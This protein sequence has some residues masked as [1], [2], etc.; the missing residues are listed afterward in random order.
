MRHRG[1]IT[2]WNDARGFGFI[3][4]D[5]G[6]ARVFLHIKAF[7][8]A[9]RRPAGNERVVYAL[10]RDGKRGPSAASAAFAGAHPARRGG[11]GA[12]GIAAASAFLFLL[13]ISIAAWAGKLPMQVPVLYWGASL[14]AFAAYLVDKSAARSGR[15]RTRESSLHLC[16][17]VGG[18]AGALLAQ[19]TLRHKSRKQSFQ[20]V[21]WV[22]V[23]AN[24][25]MLGLYISPSC[26]HALG[27]A[28]GWTIKG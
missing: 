20:S 25:G 21:F 9:T 14:L 17:L 7:S 26:R 10:A 11:A 22:T 27:V 18:W 8:K 1:R 23:I 2:S 13:A 3:T 12:G 19:Q 16:A 6:G 5:D 28:L 4:P 24:L 15:W